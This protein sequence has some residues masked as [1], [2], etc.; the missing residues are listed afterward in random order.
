MVRAVDGP[1]ARGRA[2]LVS[3][4]RGCTRTVTARVRRRR[5]S[6]VL[7]L[8]RRRGRPVGPHPYPSWFWS[9]RSCLT[10]SKYHS[11]VLS[12]LASACVSLRGIPNDLAICGFGFLTSWEKPNTVSKRP[13]T[14]TLT[15]MCLPP[16]SG[17]DP[18]LV[19]SCWDSRLEITIDAERT[20]SALPVGWR[21]SCQDSSGFPP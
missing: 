8:P 3:A 12:H 14:Y 13:S 18:S 7:A 17:S 19:A 9:S 1:R 10:L 11:A 20:A 15:F 2:E 16:R 4:V 5:G 21:A 6:G